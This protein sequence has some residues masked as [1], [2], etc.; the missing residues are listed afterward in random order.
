VAKSKSPDAGSTSSVRVEIPRRRNGK[1]YG[2]Q[3]AMKPKTPK[4]IGG[5]SFKSLQRQAD[6]RG[7]TLSAQVRIVEMMIETKRTGRALRLGKKRPPD[8][9]NKMDRTQAG[10]D[11]IVRRRR[12]QEK[13]AA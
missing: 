5:Y 7:G 10:L 13:P 2:R 12:Q 4:G 3:K 9:I 8:G 6:K 1:A 11:R